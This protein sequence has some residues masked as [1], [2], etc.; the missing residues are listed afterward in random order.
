MIGGP[1]LLSVEDLDQQIAVARSLLEDEASHSAGPATV[2]FSTTSQPP[3]SSSADL[4]SLKKKFPFLSQYSDEF[5]MASGPLALIKTEAA[6]RKLQEYD[7]GR[8]AEDKLL[9]NRESLSST[10]YAV[11]AGLDNRFDKLHTA[12]FLP[13]AACSFAKLWSKARDYL[14]GKGH[15]PLSTYDLSSIGL[16]G[17]VS[18]RGWV[19]LHDPSSTT[20]SIKMFSMGN[21]TKGKGV[22]ADFHDMEDLSELK[23]AL[24]AL[25]AAMCSV[26]PWNRSVD[27]LE[28]FLI[29]SSFC[30]SELSSVDKQ[31]PLLTKFIDYV[32]VENANRWRDM[33]PFLST[34]DLRG[35]WADFYGQKASS[36]Q[37]KSH[38]PSHKNFN[39]S[40]QHSFSAPSSSFS[41]SSQGQ[42]AGRSAGPPQPQ[43]QHQPLQPSAPSSRY[44]AAPHL[45]LDDICYLW[46]IGKCIRP[47]NDC[48]TKKGRKLRHV[49]NFRPDPT[50]PSLACGKDHPCFSNH[51]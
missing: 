44:N 24:R 21:T 31:V 47:A 32:L 8:R 37:R 6:S 48:S 27:A 22:D 2:R 7:R 43:H 36:L 11:E 50:N 28:S 25:R 49:C 51:K 4:I 42:S 29:Q 35:T 26:H 39:T 3:A 41:S 30:S 17:S 10:S 20:I 16:G 38:Q 23:N 18:A 5:I 46:N 13:G 19:E 14:G 40:K 12:R 1:E 15:P 9:A 33:E 34:R 45:F